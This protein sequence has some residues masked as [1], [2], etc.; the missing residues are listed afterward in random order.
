[1]SRTMDASV[2]RSGWSAMLVV[3][4][5]TGCGSS[6]DT[7]D[8]QMASDAT[9]T[10]DVQSAPDVQ[11]APDVVRMAD[12]AVIDDARTVDVA[13]TGDVA[14]D[15]RPAADAATEAA[16]DAAVDSGAP[17]VPPPPPQA[18]LGLVRANAGTV[19][20]VGSG[21]VTTA[22]TGVW[23]ECGTGFSAVGRD[24]Q[25]NGF[26]L[27]AAT[28]FAERRF[29]VGNVV[30]GVSAFWS[31]QRGNVTARG[32]GTRDG[33]TPSSTLLGRSGTMTDGFWV[34]MDEA[35][36]G[37]YAR[38]WEFNF[39]G[40]LAGWTPNGMPAISV[41]SGRV[42]YT[43]TGS[44]PYLVSPDN[45]DLD[46]SDSLIYVGLRNGPASAEARLFF[47]PSNAPASSFTM[48][49][50]VAATTL[51]GD[52]ATREIV[53]DMSTHAEWR[54]T[55]RQIRFDPGTVP[56]T[57]EIDYIRVQSPSV[58]R[59]N[60]TWTFDAGAEGWTA[61][62]GTLTSASGVL[63]QHVNVNDGAI[64]SAEFSVPAASR[65]RVRLRVRNGLS[66]TGGEVFFA[67]S[68]AAGFAQARSVPFAMVASDGGFR[69]Y[70]ADMTTHPAWTGTIT[71]LRVDFGATS[72]GDVAIDW[73]GLDE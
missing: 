73:I 7:S 66:E 60:P 10:P 9:L 21:V 46:A 55:I 8:A 28:E 49:N 71:K 6:G 59:L 20:R 40:S 57:Y 15:V 61:I 37:R 67:T 12:A 58:R 70:V 16:V 17:D 26:W 34:C 1:M 19:Y 30:G 31:L 44:D 5:G 64:E 50:S 43:D 24:F 52:A 23:D 14:V 39:D 36:L 13:A 33:C 48:S 54:G 38:V 25:P 29:Y 65:S 42:S 63:T 22:G 41:R 2:S 68:T 18:L 11:T 53:F 3:L 27:C 45:L 62:R 4:L 47:V 35:M 69:E 32:T 56:G 51:A 72:R